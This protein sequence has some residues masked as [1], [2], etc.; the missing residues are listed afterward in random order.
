[1][2][3]FK[4]DFNFP[5]LSEVIEHIKGFINKNECSEFE[6]DIS[7]LNLIDASRTS[8]LCSTHHFAKYPEGRIHWIL[9]DEQTRKLIMPMR[10]KNMEWRVK[11]ACANLY[12]IRA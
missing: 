10:L 9:K 7:L 4:L 12:K 11:E 3:T 8:I 5:H 1:M 6:A 2:K